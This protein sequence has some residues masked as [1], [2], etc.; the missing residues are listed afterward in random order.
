[1]YGSVLNIKRW[2]FEIS[3]VKTDKIPLK[4]CA[5]VSWVVA[6]PQELKIALGET[7][8]WKFL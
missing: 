4:V 3:A 5:R 6:L 1:V 2:Q 8:T 7:K